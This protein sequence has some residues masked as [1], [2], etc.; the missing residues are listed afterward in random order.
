MILHRSPLLTEPLGT[1][2]INTIDCIIVFFFLII[3]Q[4]STQLVFRHTSCNSF[5]AEI[6]KSEKEK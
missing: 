5:V 6:K 1:P 3:L 2:E 4:N